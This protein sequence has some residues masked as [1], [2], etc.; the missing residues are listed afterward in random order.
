MPAGLEFNIHKA[1]TRAK[2]AW[3][4]LISAAEAALIEKGPD[5]LNNESLQAMNAAGTGLVDILK[6]NASNKVVMATPFQGVANVVIADLAAAAINTPTILV[7]G[8]T[9][10]TI[11]VL[12]FFI[13][14]TGAAAGA[15]DVR[16]SDTNGTPVDVL[17]LT[18]AALTDGSRF[19]LTTTGAGITHGTEL[20]PLTANAGLRVR[21]TGGTLTGVTSFKIVVLYDVV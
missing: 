19:S 3:V 11:R 21:K 17:T 18:V 10:R 9:G 7:A 20:A 8:V 5:L 12:G 6:V 2:Q 15:T 4:G 1:V 16:L 14:N 13:I